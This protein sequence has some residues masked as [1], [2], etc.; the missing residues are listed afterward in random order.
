MATPESTDIQRIS[1][2]GKDI[3]LVGT[4]HISLESVATVQRVIEEEKPDTVCVELDERRY[5]ALKDERR[6]QN[7]NLFQVIRKGQA[8]FLMANLV[9][10]SFQKRMGLQTGVK[11]GAELAAAATRAEEMGC[12]LV[13]AD[14][15]L[16]TTLLRTWRGTGFWKRMRLM[17]ELVVSLFYQEP[18]DEEELARIRQSDALS[19]LLEEM[20]SVLPSVKTILVDERDIFMAE[21]IRTAP[22]EKVVA[23]VGAAHMGGI[24]RRLPEPAAPEVLTELNRIPPKSLISRVIP[25]AIP[26]VVVGLFVAGFFFGGR[27]QLQEA[28][29]AWILANGLLSALGAILALGHPITIASAFVAAPITSLNPTIGAGMVTGIVQTVLVPPRVGDMEKV[30]DDLT[31]FSGWWKNRVGRVLLVFVFSSLGSVA[32]TLVAFHWLKNLW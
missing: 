27:E 26:L 13:L 12:H 7:L 20:S 16:R 14:R 8:M 6:W 11:P 22:G 17:S 5:Q 31:R 1:L 10:A 3:V 29:V 15:D 25:W 24:T 9:L 18:I 23:V 2:S 4:A 21:R 19:V 28:A 32:G 30:G